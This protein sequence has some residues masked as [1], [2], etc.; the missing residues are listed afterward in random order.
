VPANPAYQENVRCRWLATLES[1]AQTPDSQQAPDIRTDRKTSLKCLI[2]GADDPGGMLSSYA[3]ALN[4]YTTHRCRVLVHKTRMPVDPQ[5]VLVAPNAQEKT[6]EMGEHLRALAKDA[7]RLIFTAGIGAGAV[8]R[9]GRLEDTEE[10]PFG[11]L[12]WRTYTGQKKCMVFLCSSPAVRGNY[13]WYHER[14]AA[15][16]WPVFTASPDIYLHVPDSHFI[17]PIINY[18]APEYTRPDYSVGPVAITFHERPP[19]AGGGHSIFVPLIA[20][21]KKKHGDHVLFGRCVEMSQRDTLAFRRRIHIGFDRLSFGAPRFGLTSLENSALG[22]INI[23]YLDQFSRALLAQTLGTE[24][25]P[26]LSPDSSHTL[27]KMLDELVSDHRELQRRMM[28]TAEWFRRFW[29]PEKLVRRL[30][31]ILES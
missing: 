27:Y 1:P 15:R 16:G 21:L 20:Q 7:D 28:E 5:L 22:L 10:V 14:F 3:W 30:A 4:T 23:V 31:A 13:Q 2:I 24:Q 29:V 8:R 18:F 25:L 17:P 26:W 9:D 11:P 12:D 19:Y 6:G